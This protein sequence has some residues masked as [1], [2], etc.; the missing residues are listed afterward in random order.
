MKIHTRPSDSPLPFLLHAVAGPCARS[1]PHTSQL[2]QVS[3]RSETP[4]LFAIQYSAM[5]CLCPRQI[6]AA[7]SIEPH[8][9]TPIH[10]PYSPPIST[11]ICIPYS[12]HPQSKQIPY[13]SPLAPGSG[14]CPPTRRPSWPLSSTRRHLWGQGGCC[15]ASGGFATAMPGSVDIGHVNFGRAQ[16][17]HFAFLIA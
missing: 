1:R 6:P 11:S 7:H 3:H 15:T 16:S 5:R 9:N 2:S 4:P 10:T 17:L 13:I 14:M 12:H 8:L